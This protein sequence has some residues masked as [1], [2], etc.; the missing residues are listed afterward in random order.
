MSQLS[1]PSLDAAPALSRAR[2][3]HR[4]FFAALPPPSLHAKISQ[5]A[6]ALHRNHG[7]CDRVL[8]AARLHV[9]LLCVFRLMP[10][11]DSAAWAP[12]IPGH[13]GRVFRGMAATPPVDLDEVI[14]SCG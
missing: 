6:P 2:P 3:L 5:I 9:S 14:A 4:L 13:G 7:I 11:T 12:P 10:A 8:D 1:L